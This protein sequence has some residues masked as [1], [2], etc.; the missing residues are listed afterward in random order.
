MYSAGYNFTFSI[1]ASWHLMCD[2][3]SHVSC[4]CDMMTSSNGKFFRFT[5]PLLGGITNANDAKLWCFLWSAPEQTAEQT[6]K[7]RRRWFETP[8]CSLWRH[9]NEVRYFG[10]VPQCRRVPP[11]N[12]NSWIHIKFSHLN[13]FGL[14]L[15]FM[16][17]LVE[18][19]QF[20]IVFKLLTA[21]Y[22]MLKTINATV[23]NSMLKRAF[24]N[25]IS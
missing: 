6:A 17:F 14:L 12:Y 4:R 18:C 15:T 11:P 25:D 20:P 21:C 16:S 13:T 3:W 1:C 7:S 2:H 22:V 10:Q 8:S 19:V 23:L 5:G 9:C 24:C